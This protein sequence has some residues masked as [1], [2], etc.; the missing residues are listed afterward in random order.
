MSCNF[1]FFISNFIDLS[2]LSLSL[3]FP[4]ES[5]WLKFYQVYFFKE[6]DF[7]FFHLFL[8]SILFISALI[9]E[10]KVRRNNFELCLFFFSSCYGYKLGLFI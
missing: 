8:I 4:D 10:Q 9:V 2:P 3:F 5:A 6:P 7:N 1:S